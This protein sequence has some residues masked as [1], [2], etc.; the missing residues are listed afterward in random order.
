MTPKGIFIVVGIIVIVLALYFSGF[1][2][3]FVENFI[4]G[5][6]GHPGLPS[7]T[8]SHGQADAKSAYENAPLIK[9]I[10]ITIIA[11]HDV[12]T[13]SSNA[14]KVE[15]SAIVVLNNGNEGTLSYRSY[16]FAIDPAFGY[17]RY[18]VRSEV[19]LETIHPHEGG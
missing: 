16:S 7:C 4:F 12:K 15:C 6:E 1:A 19:K 11:I 8:S 10:G 18:Y 2:T 3:A 13:V 17:G 5:F 9:T 14:K